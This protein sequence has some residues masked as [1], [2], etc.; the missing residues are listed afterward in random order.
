MRQTIQ[1]QALWLATAQLPAMAVGL[2]AWEPLFWI[3][4]GI[5]SASALV[6]IAA[7]VADVRW[8]FGSDR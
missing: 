6:S 8:Y 7:H 3:A 5:A 1:R 4:G 2:A